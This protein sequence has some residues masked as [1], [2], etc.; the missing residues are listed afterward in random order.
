MHCSDG[1]MVVIQEREI[2]C[3]EFSV[4][5]A[6]GIPYE[7]DRQ[8]NELKEKR[9]EN[10]AYYTKQSKRSLLNVVVVRTLGERRQCAWR[11]D[12]KLYKLTL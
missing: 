2:V 8:K 1:V 5:A 10:L 12:E 11:E 9:K 7:N 6:S 4:R 3:F